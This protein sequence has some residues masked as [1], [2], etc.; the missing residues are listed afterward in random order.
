MRRTDRLFEIIQ[1]FRHGKLIKGIDIAAKLEVSLRTV[2]RDVDTLIASGLPIEGERGVGYL[3]REPIFLPPLMLKK[4]ELEA[5][6]LGMAMVTRSADDDLSKAAASLL[7][8]IDA[9]IPSAH[10]GSPFPRGHAVY[11]PERLPQELITLR[12]IRLA[13]A[14]Q[15]KLQIVYG[16]PETG[17]ETR[18]VRPLQTEFWGKVWTLTTWCELRQDFRVFRTDRISQIDVLQEKFVEEKEKSLADYLKRVH[19]PD[20]RET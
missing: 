10:K 16:N 5:L 15:Q 3:L 20:T 19:H 17:R 8:K 18:I 9:V 11:L 7:K 13:L 1:L 14:Q 12:A 6:H 4:E 2:Y